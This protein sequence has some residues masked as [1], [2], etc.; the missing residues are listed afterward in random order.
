MIPR[1]AVRGLYDSN[2]IYCIAES[3]MHERII[4]I[5]LESRDRLSVMDIY[6]SSNARILAIEPDPE[7]KNNFYIIDE[8]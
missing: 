7:S 2:R 1:K 8:E 6:E 3:G 4:R 5:E